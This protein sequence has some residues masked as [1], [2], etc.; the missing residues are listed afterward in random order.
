[1]V[2]EECACIM[3]GKGLFLTGVMPARGKEVALAELPRTAFFQAEVRIPVW[4]VPCT[5]VMPTPPILSCLL[6]SAS[7]FLPKEVSTSAPA[8]AAE[9][10]VSQRVCAQEQMMQRRAAEPP[11]Q[12]AALIARARSRLCSAWTGEQRAHAPGME[13]APA[14]KR[15]RATRRDTS[16]SMAMVM[17]Q[18]RVAACN[19][20]TFS[21]TVLSPGWLHLDRART[22]A[23][24][25]G[26]QHPAVRCPGSSPGCMRSGQWAIF[27]R[28]CLCHAGLPSPAECC[29]SSP[30]LTR[31][32]PPSTDHRH[33][34]HR[35]SCGTLEAVAALHPAHSSAAGAA[36]APDAA[37]AARAPPTRP[38]CK[39]EVPFALFPAHATRG[40]VP[41]P[42]PGSCSHLGV[43]ALAHEG[44]GGRE[45]RG[46]GDDGGGN[47]RAEH[48]WRW[49]VT[50]R[51]FA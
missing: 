29:A 43:D 30:A 36:A 18:L 10:H 19:Q 2:Q 44:R 21:S 47:D 41:R 28:P 13:A 45:G 5:E 3:V 35:T 48:C 51:C 9:R 6:G 14:R 33:S 20:S 1:M 4:P 49:G 24:V 8:V 12:H 17:P 31:C 40:G 27:H 15:P 22:R 11:N 34:V 38:H 32:R 16:D 37:P 42:A 46:G 26:G 50:S 23:A 7:P 25:L 39:P